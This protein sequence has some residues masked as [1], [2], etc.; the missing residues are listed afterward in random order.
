MMTAEIAST[1]RDLIA[2]ARERPCNAASLWTETCRQLIVVDI[3]ALYEQLRTNAPRRHSRG[4]QYLSPKTRVG[5]TSSGSHSN[6][7]EEH[8]AI[9]LWHRSQ[10]KRWQVQGL[11]SG[12]KIIDYQTP[13]KARQADSRIGKIDLLGLVGDRLTVIELKAG[14]GSDSPLR[15]LLEGLAYCAI[16]DANRLDFA[17][18]L[19]NLGYPIDVANPPCL[20]VCAPEGY[21]AR[22]GCRSGATADLSQLAESIADRIGVDIHFVAV[23]FGGL[24]KGLGG[25]P[26]RLFGPLSFYVL[27]SPTPNL[28]NDRARM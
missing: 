9:A 18:E 28:T 21:W 11:S 5:T 14:G 13:L 19:A 25:L 26:P 7:E 27:G 1:P 22:W 4:K 23:R 8:L 15:A 16:V 17:S 20:I 6:R 10:G 24:E 3:S 2:L 12:L